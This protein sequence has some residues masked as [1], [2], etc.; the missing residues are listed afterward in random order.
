MKRSV[1]IFCLIIF[2]TGLAVAQTQTQGQTQ[3]QTQSQTQTKAKAETYLY[4]AVKTLTLKSGTGA[5]D[6]SKGTLKYG[7]K[8][9]V[10]NVD[11][12]F[13]EV[14]SAENPL[15]TGWTATNNL[16]KKQI[17]AGS[18]STTTAK[19]VALAGKGFSQETEKAMKTQKPNLNYADVDKTEKIVVREKDVKRFL[20]DGQLRMGNNS[21]K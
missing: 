13:T 12:K 19:E 2:V 14:K 4:V 7:D 16:S 17:T 6:G 3:G 20:E 9:V 10:I 18:T 15:I 21:E 5:F 8:V 1:F 11:G